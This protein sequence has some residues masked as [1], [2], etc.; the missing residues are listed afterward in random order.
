MDFAPGANAQVASTLAYGGRPVEDM[1]SDW[2]EAITGSRL[3][4]P[5]IP[6]LKVTVRSN[7]APGGI[8]VICDGFGTNQ[9]VQLLLTLAIT[10]KQSLVAI[11]EPEIHLHPKAQTKLCNVLLGVAKAQE[12]QLVITTHSQDVLYAFVSAVKDGK[13]SRDELALYYFEEKGKEPR[14]I[15]QDEYGDIYDWGKHFF[16]YT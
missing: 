5:L 12:K 6:E 11:E 14:R 3:S 1:V 2:S 15:E 8:P 16:Y 7:A 9:L 4:A 10:P 13:L